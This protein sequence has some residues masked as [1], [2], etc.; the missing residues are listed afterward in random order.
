MLDE[1]EKKPVLKQ[2]LSYKVKITGFNKPNLLK[3]ESINRESPDG[4]RLHQVSLFYYGKEGTEPKSIPSDIKLA[5]YRRSLFGRGWYFDHAAQQW[6]GSYEDASLLRDV[7]ED[8]FPD[9]GKYQ[10]L[11]GD[12]AVD[13]LAQTILA[14]EMPVESVDQ[15]IKALAE[16][17]D[18]YEVFKD[19]DASQLLAS[20]VNQY[21]QQ[22]AIETL[23]AV[24]RNPVSTES[25][26]QKV[27]DKQWWMFGGRFIDK[28][29]RRSLT[30]LDQLDIPLLRSDGSLHV[31]ELKQSNIPKLIRKH[32]NHLVVG[33]DIHEAVSQA[34]NYLVALDEQRAQILTDLGI[35][36]R[37]ASAVIVIGH[38]DFVEGFT[39]EQVYETIRIYNS[40]ISRIEVITFDELVFGARNSLI[41]SV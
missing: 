31:V 34:M 3:T 7:I 35:D 18:A 14:G 26:I 28:A 39:P 37:R 33:N 13:R 6:N 25:D 32:R 17:P 5:T 19:S 20:T 36:T 2:A 22:Q 9:S 23:D 4:S 16:N 21:H 30:V 27:L 8:K 38:T 1:T 41:F 40:H 24:A 10:Q 12:S 15:I 11:S 29:K